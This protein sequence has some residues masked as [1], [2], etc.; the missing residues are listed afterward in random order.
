MKKYIAVVIV[1]AMIFAFAACKNDVDEGQ[2]TEP[3]AEETGRPGDWV[4][5]ASGE[6]QTTAV[7][8]IIADEYSN[9]VTEIITDENGSEKV[10]FVTTLI[11]DIETNPGATQAPT[12]A[13]GFTLADKDMRWPAHKFMDKVPVLKDKISDS[14]YSKTEDGEVAVI[15]LNDISY[16]DYLKY[17]EKCKTAGFEQ[18]L[19]DNLPEKEEDGRSYSYYSIANGLYLNVI[20]NTH[21]APYRNFDVK[22]AIAN[23]DVASISSD[24]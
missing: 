11:Y 4:T 14:S 3:V 9:P 5:N 13:P 2:T 8:Y 6:L 23:Y 20:Y 15:Y 1:F 7:S 18:T 12:V 24:K 16:A 19:G 17:I 10:Q 21:S 22:I